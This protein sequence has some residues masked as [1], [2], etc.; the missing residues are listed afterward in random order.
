M[1]PVAENGPA[2]HRERPHKRRE[3]RKE[4]K[5][6]KSRRSHDRER[7]ARTELGSSVASLDVSERL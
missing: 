1:T 6:K 4:K 7:R 5:E 2:V 3:E